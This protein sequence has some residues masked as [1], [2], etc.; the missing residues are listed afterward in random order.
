MNVGDE[1]CVFEVQYR[2]SLC[3]FISCLNIS[4]LHV[5]PLSEGDFKQ[6]SENG[7]SGGGE[8]MS[9]LVFGVTRLMHPNTFKLKN[10]FEE[11]I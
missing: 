8:I 2:A 9:L 6:G 11:I 1:L 5:A 10:K 4:H 7:N 3:I